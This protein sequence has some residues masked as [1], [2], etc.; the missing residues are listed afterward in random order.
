MTLQ[1]NPKTSGYFLHNSFM[2]LHSSKRFAHT[3]KT[4]KNMTEAVVLAR[5]VI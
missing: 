4:Q 3:P 1:T 2:S 5:I